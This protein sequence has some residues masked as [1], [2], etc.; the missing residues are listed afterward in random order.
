MAHWPAEPD[1]AAGRAEALAFDPVEFAILADALGD[2]GVRE[3]V[4][5][6]ETETRDRLR[7]LCEGGQDRPTIMRELHTLKGAA[8]TVAAPRLTLLGRSLEHLVR[9][10][11]APTPHDILA[12]EAALNAYLADISSL[13]LG[14]PE[15]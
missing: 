10:G 8:S 6:F 14:G 3:I 7:R 11:G 1:D 5:I 2:D 4:W 9:Q 12:M 13:A 15:T